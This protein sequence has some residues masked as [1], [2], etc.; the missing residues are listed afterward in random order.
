VHPVLKTPDLITFT[1]PVS[2]RAF[3]KCDFVLRTKWKVMNGDQV[4]TPDCHVAPLAYIHHSM[5][6]SISIQF[7]ECTVGLRTGHLG[8]CTLAN[9]HAFLAGVRHSARW[10]P[11]ACVSV[12]AFHNERRSTR[13]TGRIEL[14][15]S[16][17]ARVRIA[18]QLL[19]N[20]DVIMTLTLTYLA[21]QKTWTP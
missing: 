1:L 17:H 19:H 12:Q 16:R 5:F 9:T 8:E 6:K 2:Q 11:T 3:T 10:L 21:P 13:L 15:N 14:R 4:L 20:C 18:A 7:A